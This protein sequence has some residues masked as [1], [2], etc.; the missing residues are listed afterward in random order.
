MLA[1]AFFYYIVLLELKIRKL[2]GK[3]KILVVNGQKKSFIYEFIKTGGFLHGLEL[4]KNCCAK[5][6]LCGYPYLYARFKVFWLLELLFVS[7][8]FIPRCS[9]L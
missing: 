3:T 9:T 8:V 6:A 7:F 2:T 4:V 1:G 5:I